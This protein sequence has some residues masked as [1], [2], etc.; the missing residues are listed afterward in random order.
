MENYPLAMLG[1]P[2]NQN[3]KLDSLFLSRIELFRRL[4][5]YRLKKNAEDRDKLN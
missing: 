5:M 4:W 3:S 2:D 1:F